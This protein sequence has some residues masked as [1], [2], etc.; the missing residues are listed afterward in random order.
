LTAALAGGANG[1]PIA[2]LC[3]GAAL[4]AL[5]LAPRRV[6]SVG[7]LPAVRG[8]LWLV[9]ADSVDAPR[10]ITDLSPFAHLA[11]VPAPPEL[12]VA[13]GLTVVGLWAYQRRDL[14]IA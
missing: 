6:V 14:R 3:V 2:A 11:A 1:L 5:G 10:W 4:L 9:I 13:A 8:F 7:S 12:T